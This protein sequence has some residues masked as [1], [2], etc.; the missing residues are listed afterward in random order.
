MTA[1]GAEGELPLDVRGETG[2]P[3][4]TSIRLT[5]GR[6]PFTGFIHQL[7]IAP[8]RASRSHGC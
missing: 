4:I 6:C 8:E 2:R 1:N 3:S 7:Q 5:S